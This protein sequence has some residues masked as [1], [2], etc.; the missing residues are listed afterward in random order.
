M[1]LDF[2][3]TDLVITY[4]GGI[5]V[6][7]E[8]AR[9]LATTIVIESPN[10]VV[11]RVSDRVTNYRDVAMAMRWTAG[12]VLDAEKALRRLR[13]HQ[14]MPTLIHAMRPVPAPLEK[15]A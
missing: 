4:V 13:D 9:R 15:A 14:N 7:G 1:G 2:S 5:I 12:G 8:L 3:K 10:P 11:R 6:A